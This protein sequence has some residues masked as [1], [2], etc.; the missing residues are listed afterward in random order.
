[1][2]MPI[3]AINPH[4]KPPAVSPCHLYARTARRPSMASRRPPRPL[5]T[6]PSI[7]GSYFSSRTH[8]CAPLSPLQRT[9]AHAEHQFRRAAASGFRRRRRFV[10]AGEGLDLP[11][12]SFDLWVRKELDKLVLPQVFVPD[13]RGSRAP[14]SPERRPSRRRRQAS[15]LPPPLHPLACRHPLCVVSRIPRPILLLFALSSVPAGSPEQPRRPLTVPAAGEAQ[16][17]P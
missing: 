12:V 16:S 10:A 6:S 3:K 9:H 17:R 7:L 13:A 14:S 5:P 8:F 15:L 2:S 4:P 11:P 1:V